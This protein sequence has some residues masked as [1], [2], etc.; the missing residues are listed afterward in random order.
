MF[1]NAAIIKSTVFAVVLVFTLPAYAEKITVDREEYENLKKAVEYLLSQQKEALETAKRAEEK[2]DEAN[3]VAIATAEV[4]ED[5]PLDALEGI[6][7]RWLWR[8]AL[9]QLI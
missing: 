2:A 4:V 8:S 5:S 7:I 3:E 9:Q 1:K 6:S